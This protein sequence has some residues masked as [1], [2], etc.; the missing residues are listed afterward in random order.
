MGL[1]GGASN[2]Y[3]TLL[4]IGN[5]LVSNQTQDGLLRAVAV[6]GVADRVIADTLSTNESLE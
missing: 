2:P 4:E 6:Q 1:A 5:L 3:R